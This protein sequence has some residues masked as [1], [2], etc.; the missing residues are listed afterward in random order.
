MNWSSTRTPRTAPPAATCYGNIS[1]VLP[2]HRT[3]PHADRSPATRWSRWTR[4]TGALRR[5][6]GT[7]ALEIARPGRP[8]RRAGH[9]V[10]PGPG[11]RGD[12]RRGTRLCR[13]EFRRPGRPLIEVLRDLNSRIYTDFTYRSGSTTVSTQVAEVLGRPGRC[14]PGL[15][16]AGHRLPACQRPGGQL[17]VGLSGHRSAAGTG[18]DGRGGRHPRLGL[19][20]DPAESVAGPGSRPTTRWSTSAM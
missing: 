11:V 13:T 17:C 8:G 14:L 18:A 15:R 7:R 6:L 10:H 2:C 12:H 19:G 5:R 16:P 1:S 9:R 3:A 4:R 20:V